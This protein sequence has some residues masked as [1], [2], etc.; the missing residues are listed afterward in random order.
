M[1]G[2]VIGGRRKSKIETKMIG[3]NHGGLQKK[4]EVGVEVVGLEII[5]RNGV[6][7]G[8]VNLAKDTLKVGRLR[9]D[10]GPT[11][12]GNVEILKNGIM[13]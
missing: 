5:R 10:G 13:N 4:T 7:G 2:T 12:I 9:I 8:A 11:R 3:Q 1:S 6:D